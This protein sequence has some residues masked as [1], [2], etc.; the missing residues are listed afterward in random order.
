LLVGAGPR[1][2]RVADA[3]NPI[4][5]PQPRSISASVATTSLS[6][7]AFDFV[8]PPDPPLRQSVAQVPFQQ[9]RAGTPVAQVPFQRPRAGTPVAQVPFQRPRRR[10]SRSSGPIPASSGR[11]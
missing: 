8:L 10:N 4:H 11:N 7:W 2:A 9:P 5:L 1:P 6:S 3:T